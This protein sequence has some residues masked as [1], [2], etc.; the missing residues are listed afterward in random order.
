MDYNWLS[1]L[2]PR[3]KEKNLP[4]FSN[5]G[6][7][8]VLPLTSNLISHYCV[9]KRHSHPDFL[10]PTSHLM[11]FAFALPFWEPSRRKIFTFSSHSNV[12]PWKQESAVALCPP[13]LLAPCHSA[14]FMMLVATVKHTGKTEV[15]TYPRLETLTHE[16]MCF[17]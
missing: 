1:F 17:I 2:A 12:S 7:F 16:M 10:T 5:S 14:L 13:L 8:W 6:L 9:A 3:T 11:T 4:Y 15:Q